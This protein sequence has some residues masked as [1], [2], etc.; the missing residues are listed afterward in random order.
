MTPKMADQFSTLR[1]ELK[2]VQRSLADLQRRLPATQLE[3]VFEALRHADDPRRHSSRTPTRD[4]QRSADSDVAGRYSIAEVLPVP[5]AEYS[6]DS[7]SRCSPVPAVD[8]PSSKDSVRSQNVTE[9]DKEPSNTSLNN[10]PIS[11]TAED[12]TAAFT[13]CL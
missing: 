5:S 1:R 2:D 4:S 7:G 13:L 6:V 3:P 8:G 10:S 12:A 11:A 9:D